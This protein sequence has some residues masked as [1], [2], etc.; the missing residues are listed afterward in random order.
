MLFVLQGPSGSGKTTQA[1]KLAR[2]PDFIKITTTTTRPPRRGEVDGRDYHFLSDPDYDDRLK[3][4]DLLAPTSI[5][6]ARY[7]IPKKALESAISDPKRHSVLVLD[8]RGAK[9]LRALGAIVI[10]L[11]LSEAERRERLKKRGD[12]DRIAKEEMQSPC[13]LT[14]QSG[15]DEE[16]VYRR[17]LDGIRPYLK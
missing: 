9:T 15:G 13:D 17:L 11:H 10:C 8:S 6:G 3:N 1:D 7:G 16:A 5:H 12:L 4:G 2:R 14:L